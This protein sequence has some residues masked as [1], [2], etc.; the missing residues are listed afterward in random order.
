MSDRRRLAFSEIGDTGGS[1]IFYF[2]GAP[3]SRWHLAPWEMELAEHGLRVISP[4]R[5]G[6]GGSS[7]QPGRTMCDWPTDVAALADALGVSRFLVAGHSSGGPYAAACAALLPDRVSG[8]IVLA[9]VTD[10]AWPEAWNGYL[11]AEVSMMRMPDEPS[12]AARCEELFGKD[13]GGL[14]EASE[15]ELPEPDAELSSDQKSADAM[16]ATMTEAFRQGIGGYAQDIFVQGRSWPFDPRAILGPTVL[17]HGE[18]DT[19]VPVAH[20]RHTAEVI[21]GASLRIL[22]EHGHGSISSELAGLC[23]EMIQ[24]LG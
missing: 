4:D 9:G 14:L 24:S 22:P 8:A 18:L 10:M 7:P 19:I 16:L 6:Y 23:T 20:S 5:P 15:V 21:P 17:V 2:H 12:A 13:G 3:S 1:V 11:E